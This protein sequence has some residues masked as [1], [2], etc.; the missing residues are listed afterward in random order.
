MSEQASI[1]RYEIHADIESDG[2]NEYAYW[3]PWKHERGEF[4]YVDDLLDYLRLCPGETV[5]KADLLTTL[6]EV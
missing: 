2:D 1:P 4:I 6:R 3:E 5:N